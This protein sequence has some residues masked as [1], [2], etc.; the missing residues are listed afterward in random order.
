MIR[1][2]KEPAMLRAFIALCIAAVI[3]V[4]IYMVAS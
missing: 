3:L 2:H 1:R 4:I